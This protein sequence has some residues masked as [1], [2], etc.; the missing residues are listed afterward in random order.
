MIS[1]LCSPA[2]KVHI[3]HGKWTSVLSRLIC[4]GRVWTSLRNDN[5]SFLMGNLG[6]EVLAGV[7]LYRVGHTLVCTLAIK[8]IL[9]RQLT[10]TLI[11]NSIKSWGSWYR[12]QLKGGPQ[13]LCILLLLLLTTKAWLCM[14]HSRNLGP[15]FYP[16]PISGKKPCR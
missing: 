1:T 9:A 13:V 7:V 6:Q 10:S 5:G 12:A 11:L 2:V 15:A 14:Q 16:S 4:G 8:L 3:P